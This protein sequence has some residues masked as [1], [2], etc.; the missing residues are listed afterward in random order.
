MRRATLESAFGPQRR[1]AAAQRD[2]RNGTQ[3]GRS[4]T[5]AEPPLLT[6]TGPIFL[7][8]DLSSKRF[9]GVEGIRL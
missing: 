8:Q 4:G 5:R 7:K 3:T 9:A 2:V 1:F 6:P